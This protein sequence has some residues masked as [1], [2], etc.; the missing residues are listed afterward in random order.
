[1]SE[2]GTVPSPAS[3]ESIIQNLAVEIQDPDVHE[4]VS[5]ALEQMIGDMR[6]FNNQHPR[7]RR[8]TPTRKRADRVRH[9]PRNLMAAQNLELAL[10]EVHHDHPPPEDQHRQRPRRETREVIDYSKYSKTGKKL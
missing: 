3:S 2:S 5:P 7:P 4:I 9:A 6:E 8:E 1:M 10:H